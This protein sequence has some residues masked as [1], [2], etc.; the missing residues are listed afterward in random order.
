MQ[1]KT[2]DDDVAVNQLICSPHMHQ[3][4]LSPP[5]DEPLPVPRVSQDRR[6]APDKRVGENTRALGEA[7]LALGVQI[8]S[9]AAFWS[10]E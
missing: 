8:V 1:R 10:G 9:I 5:G 7:G 4:A 3:L 2:P 6:R